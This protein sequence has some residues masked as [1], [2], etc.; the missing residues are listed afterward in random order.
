MPR[1]LALLALERRYFDPTRTRA[2]LATSTATAAEITR[3]Y[4][5]PSRQIEIMPNGYD[6]DEFNRGG[7]GRSPRRRSAPDSA[8]SD[9]VV[10]LFV[11]NELHR[12]G[13]ATLLEA[14]ASVGDPR[15]RIE[16][17]GRADPATYRDRIA[18]LGL[19]GRVRWNGPQSD[20][21]PWYAAADLLVLPTRYEPFGNVI[22]E[23]LACGLPGH[24]HRTRRGLERGAYQGSTDCSSRILPTSTSWPVCCAP[25]STA[26][27][28]NAGRATLGPGSS[29]SSGA[30]WPALL[31]AQLDRPLA[32]AD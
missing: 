10:L 1:H 18:E 3:I 26:I 28:C 6:P 14:V 23:A 24:H 32:G 4:G 13:F 21:A 29:D 19:A 15:M 30:R 20:I 12:K 9:Q 22:V 7:S 2:V 31:S 8:L 17:V 16:V 27:T 11:A 25:H 5:V